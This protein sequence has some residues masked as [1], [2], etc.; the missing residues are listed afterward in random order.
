MLR[1]LGAAF[2]ISLFAFSPLAAAPAT[3]NEQQ[4]A[5]SV[6][7]NLS[8]DNQEPPPAAND[9]AQPLPIGMGARALGMGEAFTGLADDISAI[10]WNPAGLVQTEKNEVQW[11]GGDH[12]TDELDTGFAA[13]NYMLQNHMNFA[14]SYERPYHPI[15]AYPNIIT[16]TY[17]GATHA[18]PPGGN[19]T[20]SGT[21]TVG[22][23]P[24]NGQSI[25]W[26]DEQS[27]SV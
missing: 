3:L 24:S 8:T 2:L 25:S 13:A 11:M 1:A 7:G 22:T 21:V 14:L 20:P 10:W 15:G 27:T 17:T 26:F 23:P 19:G 9:F 12:V 5:N 16:G 6:F 18:P 4:I